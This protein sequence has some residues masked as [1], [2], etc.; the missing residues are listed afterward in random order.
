MVVCLFPEII[1][2]NYQKD[3]ECLFDAI[4]GTPEFDYFLDLI[5]AYKVY[6]MTVSYLGYEM[7]K[8][9]KKIEKGV[10]K[11]EKQL[12]SLEKADKK[13]DKVCEMGRKE[14]MENKNEKRR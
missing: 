8:Q 3:I 7:D 11:S 14:M 9:I 12:K 2:H 1:E 6:K 5:K 13:R 4:P 10:K